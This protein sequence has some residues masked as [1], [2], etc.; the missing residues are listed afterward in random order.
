MF[1][2]NNCKSIP[3]EFSLFCWFG[4]SLRL[5]LDKIFKL[6][7]WNQQSTIVP[8]N[9]I[10]EVPR[11]FFFQESECLV[12]RAEGGGH[13]L[14]ADEQHGRA[15]ERRGKA[16]R[17]SSCFSKAW[18]ETCFKKMGKGNFVIER[19]L[20]GCEKWFMSAPSDCNVIFVVWGSTVLSFHVCQGVRMGLQR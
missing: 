2:Q 9:W 4:T 15:W 19:M 16:C 10:P 7:C 1:M 14:W 13:H 3:P 6:E 5:D 17:S 12:Q 20:K 8:F 11:H 18:E